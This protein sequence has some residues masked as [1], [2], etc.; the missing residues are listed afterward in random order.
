M[1]RF[2]SLG[3]VLL[4]FT[5]KSFDMQFQ[6][7]FFCHCSSPLTRSPL[8]PSSTNSLSLLVHRLRLWKSLSLVLTCISLVFWTHALGSPTGPKLTRSQSKLIILSRRA[9]SP[10]ACSCLFG[11]KGDTNDISKSHLSF[12]LFPQPWFLPVWARSSKWGE[13]PLDDHHLET[14]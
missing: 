13:S 6:R 3:R 8:V 14:T 4:L 12:N 2:L 9:T 10:G 7:V 5:R 11:E 1:H